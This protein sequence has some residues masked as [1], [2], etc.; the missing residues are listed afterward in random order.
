MWPP[1]HPDEPRGNQLRNLLADSE[2]RAQRTFTPTLAVIDQA[3]GVF[4]WTVDGRRLFDFTSG[5][6]VT[7]LGHNP[8]HWNKRVQ[9][10]LASQPFNIYNAVTRIEI[11]AN[12]KLSSVSNRLPNQAPHKIAWAASGSEAIHKALWIALRRTPNRDIILAT[13]H[14]FHG[15]KGLANAVTGSEADS[16]RDPRV[17]FI[18]FPRLECRDVADRDQ[19]FDVAPY[20][21]ELE[22]LFDQ[23][24]N[25][26]GT[27]ITE[28]YLGGAGSY[29]P[30]PSYLRMLQEFC[31]EHDLA[32]ILDEVQSNFGRTGK[33]FAFEKYGLEP[34]IVVL[35]KS[36][37]N[38]VPVAAVVARANWI[39]SLDFGELSD[40][41]SAN[42][43]ASAAVVATLEAYENPQLLEQVQNVSQTIET[44]LLRLK[45][46][47]MV[48]YV[49]GEKGGMVW[50]VEIR[51]HAGLDAADWAN[52]L[53]LAAYRGD[54]LTGIHLLGPLAKCVLR[55]APPLVITAHEAQQA[56]E[57]LF[58]A[59]RKTMS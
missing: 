8:P 51:D 39:D 54:G 22:Q 23:Y 44:G 49:R 25:R 17:K 52:R 31:R 29:H 15:K 34:D 10:L 37:A 9:Q 16:E 26:I 48:K 32:F 30:P 33:M 19:P 43:L 57:L 27:L 59:F 18:S 56:V 35:G 38:G 41:W 7:N 20:R 5:V 24:G 1:Q 3:E 2:P 45:E 13:R 58:D 21:K 36:L 14:G 47:P 12:Q 28:P 11:E 4:L 55:I 53:V 40:T 50:G 46:L 6:L 42:P